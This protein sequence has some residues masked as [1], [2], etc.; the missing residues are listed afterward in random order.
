MLE[1]PKI[2]N[3]CPELEYLRENIEVV[4]E[5]FAEHSYNWAVDMGIINS[6]EP[7]EPKELTKLEKQMIRVAEAIKKNDFGCKKESVYNLFSAMYGID[8]KELILV[9]STQCLRKGVFFSVS[10]PISTHS[11]WSNIPGC[12]ADTPIL[13]YGG[14][15]VAN[16][17]KESYKKMKVMNSDSLL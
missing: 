1:L 10:I 17:Y 9:N 8:I 13:Y 12:P 2:A 4:S 6:T 14:N 7:E 5:V 16:G 11:N 3:A 15:G